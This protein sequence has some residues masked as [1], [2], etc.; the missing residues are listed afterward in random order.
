MAS[1]TKCST[2]MGFLTFRRRKELTL[3]LEYKVNSPST[4]CDRHDDSLL[5]PN[6]DTDSACE[7]LIQ[8][9]MIESGEQDVHAEH[10]QARS[11]D[12]G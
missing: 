4:T 5:V 2:L 8:G 7:C 6:S 11:A 10:D 3:N 12:K 9:K 1:K